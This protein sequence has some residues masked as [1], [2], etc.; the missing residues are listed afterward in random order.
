MKKSWRRGKHFKKLNTENVRFFS[1]SGWAE[2]RDP[3]RFKPLFG[4]KLKGAGEMIRECGSISE[5]FDLIAEQA[6][7]GI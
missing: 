5:A 4:K 2:K 1:G 3:D 6:V 7:K